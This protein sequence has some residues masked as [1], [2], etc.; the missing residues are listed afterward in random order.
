MNIVGLI[1]ARGGS[2]GVY[3]KN[4]KLLA[5]KPL[6]QYTIEAALGAG[7]SQLVVSTDDQEIADVAK[8]CGASVPF[9]RPSELARDDTP[10]IPVMKHALE[11]LESQGKK[12]DLLVYLRPTTPFK[13]A[14]LI[15]SVWKRLQETKDAQVIRSLTPAEGVHHPY[16]MYRGGDGFLESAVPGVSIAEYPRRQLL[17]KILRINGVVD[18]LTREAVVQ[19][20]FLGN[21]KTIGFETSARESIDIDTE[22]DFQYC[23]WLLRR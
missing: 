17:P 7:L 5:G 3:R 23:E 20:K 16:W 1:P 4:I 10:D 13:T 14:K 18:A 11:F 2:K 22:E 8:V 21:P 6:I 15:A 9:L 12:V 19:G